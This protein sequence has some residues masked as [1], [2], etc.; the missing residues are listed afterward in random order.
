MMVA[1]SLFAGGNIW[2]QC[3]QFGESNLDLQEPILMQQLAPI[4]AVVLGKLTRFNQ[5]FFRNIFHENHSSMLINRITN[6]LLIPH[7]FIK[8]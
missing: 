4:D 2:L 1:I 6:S 8:E 3:M 7:Y 5:S